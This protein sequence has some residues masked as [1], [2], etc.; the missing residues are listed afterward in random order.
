VLCLV[1]VAVIAGVATYRDRTLRRHQAQ[2]R[3]RYG[4]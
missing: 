3:E 1:V 4:G 2:F